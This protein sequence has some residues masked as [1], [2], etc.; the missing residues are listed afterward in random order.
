MGRRLFISMAFIGRS[1]TDVLRA[2]NTS[3]EPAFPAQTWLLTGD[4]FRKGP[5]SGTAFLSVFFFRR[6]FL[7]LLRRETAGFLLVKTKAAI[8]DDL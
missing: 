2:D 1:S 7:F 3:P 5:F 4:S 8:I 6:F